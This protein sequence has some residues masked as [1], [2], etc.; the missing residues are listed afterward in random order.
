MNFPSVS[1]SRINSLHAVGVRPDLAVGKTLYGSCG[2]LSA[3]G[4]PLPK[5]MV[6]VPPGRVFFCGAVRSP[7]SA[8]RKPFTFLSPKLCV[9]STQAQ[10]VPGPQAVLN[11]F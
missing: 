11:G 7:E 4:V 10:F 9:L 5:R 8:D 1:K 2:M 6:Y 3:M